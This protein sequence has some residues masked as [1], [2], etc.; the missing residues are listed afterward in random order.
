[1]QEEESRSLLNQ[2]SQMPPKSWQKKKKIYLLAVWLNDLPPTR[3][4]IFQL[5]K[6]LIKRGC[7][8]AQSY[9]ENSQIRQ[10]QA[11]EIPV[12]KKK[13]ESGKKKKTC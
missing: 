6:V 1:M 8:R 11:Q 4:L 2:L 9:A 5:L 7:G 3:L 12:F 13:R 10:D